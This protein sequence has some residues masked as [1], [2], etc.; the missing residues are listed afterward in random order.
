MSSIKL[1]LSKNRGHANH[2]WLNSYHSFS[3]ASYYNPANMHF[4]VLR[5]LNDDEVEGGEGF[6]IHPHENMEI[7]SIPLEGALEH[8]D[9]IGNS[10]VIKKGDVQVMSA[11]TGVQHSEFNHYADKK[12]CFLQIWIFPNQKGHSPRYGQQSFDTAQFK[13]KFTLVSGPK[14]TGL[15]TWIHQ[16]AYLY[17]GNFEAGS[18]FSY[19]PHKVQNGLYIFVLEGDCKVQEYVCNKRDAL[20]I[21]EPDKEITFSSLAGAEILLMEIP[22]M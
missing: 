11:G 2:G 13:Q 22:M 4:G 7:I 1:H 10:T 17:R 19:A 16:D 18:H 15:N 5:V 14:D 3:F 8:K 9:S 20:T 21:Q 12:V 6:G